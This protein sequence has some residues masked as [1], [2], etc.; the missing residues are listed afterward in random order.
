[1]EEEDMSERDHADVLRGLQDRVCV[2]KEKLFIRLV[3]VAQIK[4]DDWGASFTFEIIPTPGFHHDDFHFSMF[5]ASASW[6]T[7]GISERSVGATW[8]SW[9]L[10]FR[11]DLVEQITLIAAEGMSARDLTEHINKLAYGKQNG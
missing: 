5:E 11:P 2:Y 7:I 8:V 10:V 9:T 4:T 3:R 1:M 6:E